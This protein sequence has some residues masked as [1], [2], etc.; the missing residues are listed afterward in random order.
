[1]DK[2]DKEA[3]LAE[4]TGKLDEYTRKAACGRDF[5]LVDK[6]HDWLRSPVGGEGI[7]A[8]RLLHRVAYSDWHQPGA[9]IT[10]DKF[11]PGDDCC[12][13]VFCILQKIGRGNL[14]HV[15]SRKG[16]VD[17][18]LPISRP[19]LE[20]IA[21]DENDTDLS[22]A[23]FELQHRFRPA[24]F[25]LHSRADWNEDTVVPICRRKPIK[26]GGTAELWQIDIP[27]EFV[28][29]TLREIS[30]GSRFN[31][32]GSEKNPDWRYEF[33]LKTFESKNYELYKNEVDAFIGL[34]GHEGMVRW[35]ADYEKVDKAA[36]TLGCSGTRAIE[37]E[38]IKTYNILLEFGAMDLRD[39]FREKRPPVLPLEIEAFWRSLSAV[40]NA[41]DGVHNL[42]ILEG[43][44]TKEYYGWHADIKPDNILFVEN[45]LK[46]VEAYTTLE[47]DQ[48]ELEQNESSFRL[49]DPGFAKFVKKPQKESTQVPKQRL[50]GGTETY[51]APEYPGRSDHPVSQA[52]DIWSL[53]C[54]FSLAATWITLGSS[55]VELF[56]VV[57][58]RAI[59][60]YIEAQRRQTESHN[61]TTNVSEG[62]QF[63]NGREVLDAVTM[64]HEY[65]R[66]VIRK[67]DSITCKVLDLLDKEMLLGTP[68]HRIK[69]TDLCSRLRLIFI[70][71]PCEKGPQLPKLFM[72]LLGEIDEEESYHAAS[73]RRSRYIAQGDSSSSQTVTHGVRKL[74]VVEDSLKSTHRPLWPNQSLRH[75]DGKYP[76]HQG[77]H[78]QTVPEQPHFTPKTFSEPQLTHH[79]IP[80]DTSAQRPSTRSRRSGTAKRHPPQNYFQA[81]EAIKKR[82]HKEKIGKMRIFSKREEDL[83]DGLLVS[84]FRGRRDIIFLVD[85]A[86]SMEVH[87]YEATRLL[88]VLVKKAKGVDDDGMDLR[89][90][91]GVNSLDGENSAHQF[92]KS[93]ERARPKTGL[94]ERAHTDLRSSL[95]D[96][97]EE[98]IRRLKRRSGSAK[99]VAVIIL[100]DGVWKGMEDPEAV[101]DHIRRFTDQLKNLQNL[102]LRPFSIEFIQFGNDEAATKRLRYLDDYLHQQGIPDIVDT[103]HS[104]GDVNKML[105]GS[106]VEEYDKDEGDDPNYFSSLDSNHNGSEREMSP[107][108]SYSEHTPQ[109]GQRS[110]TSPTYARHF[111]SAKG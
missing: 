54:V 60:M 2:H 105:L 42:R 10:K 101:A 1:M 26:P 37:C 59:K 70:S 57:R 84:Y 92:V 12:L 108:S 52:I 7:H 106:F 104:T 45:R 68:E 85:N 81:C 95:G 36:L 55:G 61:Q 98:Y 5:V 34:K 99:D 19:D 56:H 43:G 109:S 102:K 76:E 27:E 78:L 51:G 9:P 21:N 103:E 6:L 17:R 107:E 13:L 75:Q 96:I 87:W 49:A 18:L 4:F 82:E 46:K 8:D 15:F 28:G 40:A 69:A 111:L 67:S 65:L 33:A 86:E 74:S 53:G 50:S 11:K 80:S 44:Q 25:D 110:A 93:M 72:D 22:S 58:Q 63:H 66:S 94:N 83:R 90:T 39:Y 20:A 71:C 38:D 41:V 73:T 47:R 79:R 100:T 30:S 24:R 89:F 48:S 77:L 16:K 64:W 29:H 91:T 32:G 35:L 14:L 31:E 88:E 3:I 97:S 62:D 23:F